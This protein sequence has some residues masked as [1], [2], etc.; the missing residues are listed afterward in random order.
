LEEGFMMRR[1]VG[2]LV[3]AL[4]A[5]TMAVGGQARSE[6]QTAPTSR[7]GGAKKAAA[8]AGLLKITFDDKH[9][10]WTAAAIESLPRRR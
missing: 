7:M 4:V 5:G 8:P 6:A 9:A 1:N 3:L 10:E 2:V